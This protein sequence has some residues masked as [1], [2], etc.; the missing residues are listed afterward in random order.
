[1]RRGGPAGCP[2]HGPRAERASLEAHETGSAAREDLKNLAAAELALQNSPAAR[3]D[4]VKLKD[5]SVK[6][7]P[8]RG[9]CSMDGSPR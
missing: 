5:V 2:G 4:A 8:M 6:S 9:G 7:M 3:V 1:M